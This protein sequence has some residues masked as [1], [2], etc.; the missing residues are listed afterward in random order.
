MVFKL[1]FIGPESIKIG[2]QFRNS[3]ESIEILWTIFYI[4]HISL[5]PLCTFKDFS[6]IA[7][8]DS[9][10]KIKSDLNEICDCQTP[11]EETT[12]IP[13][14]SVTNN[15]IKSNIWKLLSMRDSSELYE[16]DLNTFLNLSLQNGLEYYKSYHKSYGFIGDFFDFKQLESENSRFLIKLFQNHRMK[17]G[18]SL[19]EI[20]Q[21]D[22]VFS[23]GVSILDL[24]TCAYSV[25]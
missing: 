25:F 9:I 22:E 1:F 10:N 12:F 18:R 23:N 7:C 8:F 24:Y 4:T 17:S 20:E 16:T 14:Y 6:D 13:T 21:D 15:G 11:C 5:K 3:I 19:K 2:V